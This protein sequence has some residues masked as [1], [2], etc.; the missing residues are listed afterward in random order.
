VDSWKN[1]QA[2]KYVET[3]RAELRAHEGRIDMF[4]QT[5]PNHVVTPLIFP[6]NTLDRLLTALPERPKFVT[7][8][9][10]PIVPDDQGKLHTA[11]VQ[12]TE[13]RRGPIA[14]CGWFAQATGVDI[15]LEKAVY[16]WFWV[17]KL[18]YMAQADTTA[19]VRFG[20]FS[21]TLQLRKGPNTVFLKADEAGGKAVRLEGLNPGVSVCVD[22]VVVGGFRPQQRLATP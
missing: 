6:A 12:G 15:P 16:T 9:E 1:P 18:N 10:H 22:S 13:T 14:G 8:S 4:D 20:E 2:K 11:D 21:H 7:V 3:L 19:T 17:V 5:V